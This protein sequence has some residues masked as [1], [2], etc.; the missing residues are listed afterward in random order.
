YAKVRETFGRPIGAYQAVRHPC[1]DMAV[2]VEAARCQLWYAAAALKEGRADAPA[3]L[4]AAKHLP[5]QAPVANPPVNI[6][7]PATIPDA[8]LLS[9]P[10]LLLSRVSGSKRALLTE[11][12]HAGPEA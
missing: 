5:N 10:A 2:R 8:H 12:L 9:K 6:H 7:L 1:A 3:H 4:N 11:L